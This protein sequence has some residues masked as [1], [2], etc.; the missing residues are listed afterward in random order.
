VTLQGKPLDLGTIGFYPTAGPTRGVPFTPGGA[1]IKN[2]K[3]V[4]PRDPGLAPGKYKVVIS[5]GDGKTP[6][7]SD[8]PPGPSGNF[9][10]KDRIPGEY[11]IDTKLE[12]EVTKEGPNQ[13]DFKIP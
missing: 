8:E 12:V 9:T 11:N 1:L 7:A 5:S 10:S 4:V 2:G 3:Y 13:F 6:A